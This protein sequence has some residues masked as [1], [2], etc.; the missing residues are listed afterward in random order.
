MIKQLSSIEKMLLTSL[1]FTMTLLFIRIV[2]V[3]TFA[4]LFY[5]WNLFLATI[6]LLCSRLLT[7]RKKFDAKAICLMIG[8]FLFFP[9]APYVITDLFHFTERP[10]VPLWFDMLL[11]TSATW[12]GLLLGILS[13][14]QV[15][16]F[17]AARLKPIQVKAVIFSCFV[18]CGFGIYLGRFLRFNSW[19]VVDKPGHILH[20]SAVQVLRPH[21][22]WQT[23]MFTFLFS[24]MFC[25]IYFTLKQ[26]KD[27]GVERKINPLKIERV[28][29]I[30]LD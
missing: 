22:H 9:N 28:D 14:M 29:I 2:R 13:L 5:A 24:A 26:M 23:W 17:L 20:A 21:E 25:I 11:A 3:H 27:F 7:K 4:Y 6:P 8:W 15:E 18:L 10:P 30:V 16:D 12:N 19:D 1:A